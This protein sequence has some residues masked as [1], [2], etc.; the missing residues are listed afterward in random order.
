MI[1][2]AGN[3][4]DHVRVACLHRARCAPQ[5]YNA[6]RATKRNVVKPAR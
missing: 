1:G 2:V 6:A 5:R 3:A 4:S